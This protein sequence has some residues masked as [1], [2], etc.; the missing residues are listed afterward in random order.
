MGS[1]V[2]QNRANSRGRRRGCWGCRRSLLR[3]QIKGREVCSLTL[4]CEFRPE[5]GA[6]AHRVLEINGTFSRLRGMPGSPRE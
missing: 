3:E 6:A 1:P 4:R 2:M 5:G